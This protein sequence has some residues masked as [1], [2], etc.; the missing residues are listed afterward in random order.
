MGGRGACESSHTPRGAG[1]LTWRASSILL[2]GC[3]ST[4]A[5]GWR[6]GWLS[7][8]EGR[9]SDASA[10]FGSCLARAASAFGAAATRAGL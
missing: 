9:L 6:G 8:R 1:A 3:S 4:E 2:S 7:Q 5:S 10:A